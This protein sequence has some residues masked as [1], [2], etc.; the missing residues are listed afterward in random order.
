MQCRAERSYKD[1][2][3]REGVEADLWISCSKKGWTNEL[4]F[5]DW[6]KL[7]YWPRIV[8]RG[9]EDKWKLLML[10]GHGAHQGPLVLEWCK[11]HKVK[12]G[13][14]IPHTSHKMQIMDIQIFS[15]LKQRH[16]HFVDKISRILNW[17]I[18]QRRPLGV[19]VLLPAFMCAWFDT[20]SNKQTIIHGFT[21]TGLHPPIVDANDHRRLAM[22]SQC[23]NYNEYM[24]REMSGNLLV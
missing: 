20:V 11:Q 3:L 15:S 23:Y 12:L 22:L 7:V 17:K 8:Q 6:I 5:L 21:K 1:G 24:N 9:R 16:R 19:D 4:V 13:Y 2:K 14:H 18:E 10:D